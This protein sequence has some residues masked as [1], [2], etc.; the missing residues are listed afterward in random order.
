MKVYVFK[1]SL[2]TEDMPVMQPRIDHLLLP[3]RWSLDLE[4][5]DRVLRVESDSDITDLVCT[6]LTSLGF[7]CEDLD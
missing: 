6:E 4:D 5:C 7:D 1:T 3:C 2:Q